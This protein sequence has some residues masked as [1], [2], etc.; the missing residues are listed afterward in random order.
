M[1][2]VTIHFVVLL[3][4]M[5]EGTSLMALIS[6]IVHLVILFSVTM[7]GAS[8]VVRVWWMIIH[9]IILFSVMREGTS[10]VAPIWMIVCLVVLVSVMM[11]GALLVVI[12]FWMISHYQEMCVPSRA[13]WESE[14]HHTASFCLQAWAAFDGSGNLKQ[15]SDQYII[16]SRTICN[17]TEGVGILA[18]SHSIN[19]KACLGL[20]PAWCRDHAIIGPSSQVVQFFNTHYKMRKKLNKT[21]LDH[22]FKTIAQ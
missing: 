14:S 6:T 7:E 13:Q 21:E 22:F 12:I 8:L 3:S 16:I 20:L 11:E 19:Q 18:A 15:R 2:G 5:S 17:I 4:V 9:S 1:E 10:L